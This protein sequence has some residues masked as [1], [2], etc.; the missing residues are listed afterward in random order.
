MTHGNGSYALKPV[1]KIIPYMLNGINGFV[2]SAILGSNAMITAQQNVVVIQATAPNALTGEFFLSRLVPGNYDVVF[3]ANGHTTTVITAVPVASNSSIVVFNTSATPINLPVSA[4]HFI[5]GTETL[6][7][8]S[9]TEVAYATAK[10]TLGT[11]PIITVKSVAADDTAS[12]A[13][14][15]AL[16]IGAPLLGHYSSSVPITYVAQSGV[17]GKYTLEASANGYQT[18]SVSTDI[19]A[20]DATQNFILV[21]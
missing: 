7:L 15:L 4:T 2:D 3:T 13:Y 6:N 9:S 11:T 5:S 18:Q 20:M 21:P 17:A 1:I 8:P 19:S 10:Q 14:T 12:G 16:P